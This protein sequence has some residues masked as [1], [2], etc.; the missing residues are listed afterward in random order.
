DED[1]PDA[2]GLRLESRRDWRHHADRSA[3]AAAVRPAARHERAAGRRGRRVHAVHF[4]G[5]RAPSAGTAHRAGLRAL[6]SGEARLMVTVQI[7]TR[8]AGVPHARSFS[9]WANA[10]FAAAATRRAP[11]SAELTIRVVGAAESRR[12]NRTWR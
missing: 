11:E 3:A 2:H 9:R 6:R 8:R 4:E 7:A 1:V 5:R 10:A 12:L